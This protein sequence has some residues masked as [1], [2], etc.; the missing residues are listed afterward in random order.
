MVASL[1]KR[2]RAALFRRKTLG[3]VTGLK[4]YRLVKKNVENMQN[5]WS[6]IKH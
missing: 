5:T 1:Q 2:K 6:T 3:C 4:N